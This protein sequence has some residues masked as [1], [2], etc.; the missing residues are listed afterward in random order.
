MK[1]FNSVGHWIS[2]RFFTGTIDFVF[3]HFTEVWFLLSVGV[4]LCT[5]AHFLLRKA[6][7]SEVAKI[8]MCLLSIFLV[9]FG[10]FISAFEMKRPDY[11]EVWPAALLL[12]SGYVLSLAI[13]VRWYWPKLRLEMRHKRTYLS[14]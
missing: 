13:H 3:R 12:V 4:I 8:Q 6:M 10:L 14:H 1:H 5:I 7:K 11:N 9:I 2:H